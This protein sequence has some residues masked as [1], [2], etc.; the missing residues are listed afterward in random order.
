MPAIIVVFVVFLG[1]NVYLWTQPLSQ[2]QL[3]LA[4]TPLAAVFFIW[5]LW[6]VARERQ[7]G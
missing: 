4:A 1:V 5:L 3:L 2:P 7:P 6:F